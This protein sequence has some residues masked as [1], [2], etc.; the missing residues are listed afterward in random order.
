MV[1]WNYV[2][3]VSLSVLSCLLVPK[4]PDVLS[5]RNGASNHQQ[6]QLRVLEC[7]EMLRLL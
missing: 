4:N 5:L 2:R 3:W 7:T 6:Q 1:V